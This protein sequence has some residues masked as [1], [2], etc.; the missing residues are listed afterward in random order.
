MTYTLTLLSS[1]IPLSIAHIEKVQQY[2]EAQ[3]IGL[4][5]KPGWYA[6]HVAAFVPVQ[7]AATMAQ[8][9]DLRGMLQ[10]DRIDILCTKTDL[11]VRLFLA[12]MDATIVEGETLDELAARAGIKDQIAGITARA[13]NGELDFKAALRERVMLLKGLPVLALD[14]T[15]AETHLTPGAAELVAALKARSILCVLVSGGF[16]FFTDAIGRKAGFDHN[17]GNSLNHDGAALDGTVGEPI[18][19]KDAKLA[20]LKSYAQEA[21]IDLAQTMAIGDGANDLPMLAAAG[22]G[23]GYRPKPVLVENLPNILRY[24]DLDKLAHV[25]RT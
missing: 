5:G 20:Y 18:L 4:R 9:H 8:M 21:G 22:L 7:N 15:L 13:M 10:E 17:H 6:A 3:G 14:E 1:D 11:D 25:L 23:I 19:D 12:D 16:K 24:A 2:C